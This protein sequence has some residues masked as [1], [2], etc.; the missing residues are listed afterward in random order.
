MDNYKI[1][2]ILNDLFKLIF[3]FF[4]FEFQN[5]VSHTIGRS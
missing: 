4:Y 2:Y 5:I 3:S 1:I